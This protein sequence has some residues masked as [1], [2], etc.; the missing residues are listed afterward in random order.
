M[1]IF[2]RYAL[3]LFKDLCIWS[4]FREKKWFLAGDL[5]ILHTEVQA[6]SIYLPQFDHR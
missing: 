5:R 1:S 2:M 3:S 4:Y 6:I